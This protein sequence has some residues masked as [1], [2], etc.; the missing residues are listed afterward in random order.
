MTPSLAR[1]VDP[2]AS[3]APNRPALVHEG[4]VITY[5]DLAR[6]RDVLAGR[7]AEAALAGVRVLV[8][9][10]ADGHEPLAP[11]L[12][13]DAA[14]ALPRPRPTSLRDGLL[15]HR[16]TLV[17]T[18]IDLLAQLVRAPGAN[19]DWFASLRGIYTGETRC[20]ARCRRTSSG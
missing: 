19:A 4:R 18:H 10:H 5:G 17:C 20:R 3:A 8:A 11:L 15:T 12:E 7:M 13:G 14:G 1:L 9:G 2:H 16:P 6:G